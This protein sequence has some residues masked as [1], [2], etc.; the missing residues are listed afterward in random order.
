MNWLASL[1]ISYLLGSISFSYLLG[2]KLAGIDIRTQGSGNAGAT[3]TLRVLGT[4]PAIV[5][6]ILDAVKGL[7]AM[8]AAHWLTD[9][10]PVVYAFAGIFAIIGHNWPLFFGFRGGKGIAT[11]LGVS[12][13]LSPTSFL[14]SA[15]ITV[16]VIYV[17][18]YVS[19]GSLVYVTIFPLFLYLFGSELAYVWVSLLVTFFAYIRHYSNIVNLLEGKERKLGERSSRKLN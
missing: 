17:T 19:V 13:G 8:G 11:A 3:N 16:V 14:L 9:G 4:G 2:K 5:V 1:V 15:L 12:I 6:L 10:N 18:R 7:A